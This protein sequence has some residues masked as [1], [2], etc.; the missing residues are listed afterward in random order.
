M[1]NESIFLVPQ[2]EIDTKL[3]KDFCMLAVKLEGKSHQSDHDWIFEID[4]NER[5]L[6]IRTGFGQDINVAIF[7]G[8]YCA[9]SFSS[10]TII[11]PDCPVEKLLAFV[12]RLNRD[13][14]MVKFYLSD[15]HEGMLC[16][17]YIFL[18]NGGLTIEQFVKT[19]HLYTA[20]LSDA[21]KIAAKI[22]V[23]LVTLK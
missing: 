13:L 22:G 19:F 4:D 15:E 6:N 7:T 18:T 1:A 14:H 5:V 12:D 17:D 8:E 9:I 23:K 10:A 3:L 20:S 21:F 2:D 11:W 16:C